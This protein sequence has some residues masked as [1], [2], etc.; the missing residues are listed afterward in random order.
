MVEKTFSFK[1]RAR[2]IKQL[3]EQLIRSESIALL[4]L[5]KNSYDADASKC[6]VI[7][8][9]PEEEGKGEILI[10]DDGEGMDY[11][12]LET[13]W[14]E[15]GS[16]Y[17]EDLLSHEDPE[18]HRTKRFKRYRLGEKGIGRLGVHRLGREIEIVTRKENGKELVLEI[19]WND[20]ENA[21][22]LEDVPIL[23]KEQSPS[24]FKDCSGTQIHIRKLRVP[25]NKKMARECN[26]SIVALNSP[27]DT[28]DSFKATLTIDGVDWFDELLTFED[29]KDY[30]LFHFDI[31]MEGNKLTKL[32]YDFLPWDTM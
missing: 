1:T 4:E 30:K 8:E 11:E 20:I 12:T 31:E 2:L 24:V 26:R 9:N 5:I 3:G 15:I 6:E 23:I 32:N 18:M 13:G 21:K 7:M 16:S 17:K 19:D 25:W 14:L 27:F 28:D 10:L 22:Y 29:V